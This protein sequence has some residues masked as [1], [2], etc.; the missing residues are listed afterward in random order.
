MSQHK[1]TDAFL[2]FIEAFGSYDALPQEVVD[3]TKI[4]LFDAVGNTLGGI[5]S[6]KGKIG[7]QLAAKM[8][9]VPEATVYGSGLKV[10]AATAAFANGELQNGLDYDPVPHVPPVVIPAVLAMAEAV[11]ASGKEL[12][13]AC[14]A[15]A[16]IAG[17][18]SSVL[19]MAMRADNEQQGTKGGRSQSP[20]YGNSNEHVIGAA[21]SC[22]ML[23]KLD[24][25]KMAQCIGLAAA[26][27]S[28]P[29]TKDWGSTRPKA[30]IKYFPASWLA[31]TAVMSARLAELGYTANPWTLDCENGFPKIYCRIPG[32]WDPDK[33][34]E[35]LGKVWNWMRIGVKPYPCCRYLHSNLDC[36]YKILKTNG[37]TAHEIEEIRC[38]SAKFM[39]YE[40]QLD[41]RS[42][43]DAQFSGPYT[44]ALAAFGFEPGPAWQS[45]SLMQD[46][47]IKAFMPKVKMYVSQKHYM[48][49]RQDPKSWYAVVEVDARGKT[50]SAETYYSHG[51]NKDGFRISQDELTHRFINNSQVLLPSARINEAMDILRNLEKQKDLDALISAI[52]L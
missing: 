19:M 40:T 17:R 10:D 11:G 50:F 27:C 21:V 43:V 36:L 44:I 31:R 29:I 42:Q 41:V 23:L 20:I 37:L 47:Q 49:R 34:I 39:D 13:T 7:M 8:G 38:Y 45:K 6:D 46:P 25:E 35:G 51:T 18:L 15:G 12:I 24:R 26:L 14:A 5:A 52:K 2:D 3:Q 32:I 4:M 33:V 9:G 28:L 22:G 1:V 48:I 30:M 16:E